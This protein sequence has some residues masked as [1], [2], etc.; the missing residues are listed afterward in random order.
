MLRPTRLELRGAA[1]SPRG[2]GIFYSNFDPRRRGSMVNRDSFADLFALSQRWGHLIS[3]FPNGEG[4]KVAFVRGLV[5]RGF[6]VYG[7]AVPLR[8]NRPIVGSVRQLIQVLPQAGERW[9]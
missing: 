8:Y 7:L 2:R 1:A 9:N 5:K 4:G 6:S 3:E